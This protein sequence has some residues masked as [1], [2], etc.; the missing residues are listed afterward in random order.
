VDN[1]P[2]PRRSSHALGRAMPFFFQAAGLRNRRVRDSSVPHGPALG[3]RKAIRGGGERRVSR[4]APQGRPIKPVVSTGSLR[5]PPPSAY[6]VAGSGRK[7]RGQAYLEKKGTGQPHRAQD[8][9]T[10]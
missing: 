1:G 9:Q 4:E 6:T 2:A 10:R 8:R 5:A 3:R 7:R